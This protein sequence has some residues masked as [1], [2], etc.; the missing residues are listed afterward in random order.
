MII[1]TQSR[2]AGD[3]LPT[4]SYKEAAD[5]IGCTHNYVRMLVSK[6]DIRV[7]HE[8]LTSTNVIKKLLYECDVKRYIELHRVRRTHT[9]RLTEREHRLVS[10][11]LRTIKD[12]DLY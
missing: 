4:V 10:Q 5:M 11:Y 6:G 9:Y 2:K 8:V 12:V 1:S 7:S 3:D